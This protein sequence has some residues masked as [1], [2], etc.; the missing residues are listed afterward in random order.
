M[1]P[2]F[3]PFSSPFR[4]EFEATDSKLTACR[5]VALLPRYR[6]RCPKQSPPRCHSAAAT[7]PPPPLPTNP[8]ACRHRCHCRRLTVCHP[9]A[10]S[11]L[12]PR[13]PIP[14]PFRLLSC[15]Q[16]RNRR[17]DVH[18]PVMKQVTRLSRRKTLQPRRQNYAAV[19]KLN[20]VPGSL[21]PAVMNKGKMS[22][23]IFSRARHEQRMFCKGVTES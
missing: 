20:C 18:S 1:I 6:Y 11:R 5:R 8:A 15:P 2:G 10:S 23:L 12:P 14:Q 7:L 21:G 19:H 4:D 9:A 17:A 13:L 3:N 16:V 22:C